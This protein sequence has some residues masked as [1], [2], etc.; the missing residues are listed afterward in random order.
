MLR[1][2][3]AVSALVATA[4]ALSIPARPPE[5][6]FVADEADV[7]DA[8]AEASL[9]TFLAK[10]WREDKVPFYVVTVHS[11]ASQMAQL[12]TIKNYAFSVYNQWGIGS[13]ERNIGILVLM[14]K[15]DRQARIELGWDW[16]N[17]QNE[18]AE[19]I[20]SELM[21]PRFKEGDHARALSRTLLLA[22]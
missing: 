16:S 1:I 10:T 5:G 20:M 11:L 12:Y 15:E 17:S 13:Q 2:L 8:E 21:V 4:S 18:E 14:S 19:R 3:C 7:L 6:V 9:N 22:R